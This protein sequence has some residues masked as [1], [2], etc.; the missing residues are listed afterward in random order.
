ME[1]FLAYC[2]YLHIAAGILALVIAPVAMIAAKGKKLHR[3][4]GKV[5]FWAMSAVAL[6]AI[7]ISAIKPIPFLLMVAVFSYYFVVTGYRWLYLKKLSRGQKATL[8]DW[9][10][11]IITLLFSLALVGWG[12]LGLM[13]NDNFG[14]GYV[15]I[16]FGLLGTGAALQNIYQFVKPPTDKNQ[17]F[18][19]HMGFMIGG[20]ISTVSAFSAVNMGFLPT[21]LQWLWPTIV[22]VPVV[23]IWTRYYKRKF[24]KGKEPK[25]VA[26]VK[27]HE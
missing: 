8:L 7:I 27:I 26:E 9:V 13:Q 15:A 11:G 3:L 10:I 4:S 16:V 21:V 22:G 17:W 1:Q 12:I 5:Y 23:I 24:N 14:F 20:Y 6:T 2:L 25:E 19:A 18:F